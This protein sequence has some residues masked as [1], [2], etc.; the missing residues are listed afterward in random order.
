MPEAITD[1]LLGY[2]AY[3][4]LALGQKNYRKAISGFNFTLGRSIEP[5]KSAIGLVCA[6]SCLGN[7]MK[8]LKVYNRYKDSIIFNKKFRHQLVKDLSYF[9]SED[10]SALRLQR[11]GYFSSVALGRSMN[12]VH[13]AYGSDNSNIVSIILISFWYIFTGHEFES[14]KKITDACLYFPTLD[15]TF[16]WKLLNRAAID[17]S[18]LLQDESLA[19]L[20]KVIP[21]EV[22][23]NE[24]INTIIL[25]MLYGRDLENA[26]NNI[27]I[28][29][30]KGHIF[31]NELMWNFI[32]LSVEEDE[33]DDLSVNFAKHLISEGWADSLIAE[34]IR[35]GYANRSRYSVKKELNKLNYF[36]L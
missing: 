21:G 35:F 29:R 3:S 26:R 30:L 11:K 14:I 13:G 32:R 36:N 8:A 28:Y 27:E 19:A 16:R 24:Y 34:V 17:D 18:S 7:Y 23:S 20:F 2:Y 5:E 6:Y 25:S 9:L 1:E 10:T 4:Y 22:A 12:R 31:T 33:V 15:D